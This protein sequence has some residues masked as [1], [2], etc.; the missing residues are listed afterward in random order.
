[1][2]QPY[3]IPFRPA[4]DR[5]RRRIGFAPVKSRT[6]KLLASALGLAA[7]VAVSGC[8]LQENADLD[9]GRELF[10]TQC[11]T[12]HTLAEAATTA[13]IGPDLDASFADARSQG[14]DS[15]TVEGVLE[16]QI[17]NPR[18]TD[19][20]D[21]TYMP[22]DLVTGDD[23]RDVSAYVASVAGVPGIMPPQAPGGPGGQVFANNGCG[24]CHVLAAAQSAGNVGPNLDEVLPGQ[25]AAM[26][27][28]SIVDPSA[29]ITQGFSDGVMPA[30]YGQD[31]SPEDLKLLVKFLV[32]SA[33][34]GGGGNG[35]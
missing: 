6:T 10:T 35:G 34:K 33:G 4:A 27:D 7:V 9:N 5:P 23:A 12:C 28:E 2:Q 14:F 21:P 19:P 8:D 22:A 25:S 11:G 29:M 15:D 31:I 17:S 26:V 16:S 1:L 30:T 20:D 24:A 13:D 3:P 32:D 18:E